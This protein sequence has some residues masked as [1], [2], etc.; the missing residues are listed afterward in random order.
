MSIIRAHRQLL[1]TLA[2]LVLLAQ[3]LAS[4]FCPN[5]NSHRG[6]PGYFDA[7]LGWMTI[8][9]ANSPSS[10]GE[11][12][13]PGGDHGTSEH[14]DLCA[15]LCAAVA[16]TVA[17][18]AAFLFAAL[19]FPVAAPAMVFAAPQRSRQHILFGGIGSRAPPVLV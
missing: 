11:K 17:A 10:R 2:G 16:T 9:L 8:C 19:V 12:G 18:F 15:A 7:V 3:V 14:S 6:G 13:Q 4:S 5:M 1:A